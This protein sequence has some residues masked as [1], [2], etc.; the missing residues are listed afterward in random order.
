MKFSTITYIIF[1][2]GIILLQAHNEITFDTALIC[3]FLNIIATK[4]E[5]L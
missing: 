1:V 3:I 5:K 4:K 2:I